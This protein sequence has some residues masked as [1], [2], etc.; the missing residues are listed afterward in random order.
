M[1]RAGPNKRRNDGRET[2]EGNESKK[3]N[4]SVFSSFSLRRSRVDLDAD[5][6]DS[7]RGGDDGGNAGGGVDAV[8]GMKQGKR[9]RISYRLEF[10]GRNGKTEKRGSR[11]VRVA[12]RDRGEGS[13]SREIGSTAVDED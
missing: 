4:A 8:G 3:R 11:D 5:L 13:N 7:S 12:V 6:L 9:E 2:K 10:E 1:L